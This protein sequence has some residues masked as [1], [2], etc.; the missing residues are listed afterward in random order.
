[1]P[2]KAEEYKRFQF[3]PSG[4]SSRAILGTEG[5]IFWNSGYEH[6]ELVT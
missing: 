3:T 5:V 6:D 2:P 4:V 1:M